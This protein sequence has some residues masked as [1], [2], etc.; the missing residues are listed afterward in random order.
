MVLLII[1]ISKKAK[2]KTESAESHEPYTEI[3]SMEENVFQR[4]SNSARVVLRTKST[5]SVKGEKIY[6]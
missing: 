1:K 6:S 2:M 3:K 5:A 4:T